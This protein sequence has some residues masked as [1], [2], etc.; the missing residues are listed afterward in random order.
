MSADR[1]LTLVE[2]CQML[3]VHDDTVRRWGDA[4]T[5]PM[6]RTPGGHRRYP[7]SGVQTFLGHKQPDA[8]DATV[9]VAVYCRVSSHEQKQKGD[10]D[11]QIGRM[12]VHC[13][14][15]SYTV[16]EILDDV[17]SGLSDTRPKL[18]KLF[19]LV[20]AGKVNRVVVEHKDRL[21]RFGF[22][23]LQSYFASHGVTIEWVNEVLG[24]SYEDE[25]VGD[26]LALMASFSA[27]IYGR[28][29]AENRRKKLDAQPKIAKESV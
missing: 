23:L 17:G 7:L 13:A 26:I 4:G 8:V 14:A 19:Q 22:S 6:V 21:T 15:K 24:K 27:R 25:L 12:S 18:Q 9:K 5:L 2:T 10:L 20:N 29:S 11:R 16:V 3:G 1:L 28:R